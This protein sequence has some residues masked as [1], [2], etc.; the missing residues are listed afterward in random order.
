MYDETKTNCGKIIKKES[1]LMN[2][3]YKKEF[4][5]PECNINIFEIYHLFEKCKPYINFPKD[6]NQKLR[7]KENAPEEIKRDWNKYLY[8]EKV[9]IKWENNYGISLD[10]R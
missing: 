3:K 5:I 10:I 4:I 2:K 7:L 9:K 8:L 6:L 1:G